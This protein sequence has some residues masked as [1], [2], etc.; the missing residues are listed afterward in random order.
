[1][2]NT[3]HRARSQV[4]SAAER[5]ALL[6]SITAEAGRVRSGREAETTA[7][8]LGKVGPLLSSC[9]QGMASSSVH[10]RVGVMCS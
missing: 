2:V 5:S 4:T 6:D 8:V 3:L 1:M 10:V 7:S 9:T